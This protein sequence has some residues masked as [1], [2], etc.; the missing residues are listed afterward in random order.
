MKGI[1]AHL[2]RIMTGICLLAGGLQAQ[3]FILNPAENAVSELHR[4]A[5]TVMG[6]PSAEATLYVNNTQVSSGEIRVDGVYDFLNIPVPDGPVTIRV[7]APGAGG[8]IFT[9]ER[10]MHVLGPPS[11]V[12]PY[13]DAIKIEADGKQERLLRFEIR[14]EWGY[15]LENL[16][17]AGI[18]ITHGQ[19]LDKDMDS[20]SAGIQVPL[21][22]G[23]LEFTV[24][25]P[26]EAVGAT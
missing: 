21:R 8:R 3:M 5:V 13:E 19:I 16:K 12:L 6:K 25:T 4:I 15:L 18:Q 2:L 10:N 1:T 11:K 20:L 14:D 24:R 9:A 26:K 23:I 22:N 17:T 7:E